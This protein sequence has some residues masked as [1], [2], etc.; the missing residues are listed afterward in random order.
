MDFYTINGVGVGLDPES[1]DRSDTYKK[2]LEKLGSSS[3][4][5][6]VIKEFISKSD[7][8]LLIKQTETAERQGDQ[9]W[10]GMLFYSEDISSTFKPYLNKIEKTLNDKFNIE[11]R[12]HTN[13][14]IVR[15]GIGH[16]LDLH[17]DE[18]S[19]VG[20]INNLSAVVYL[21]DSYEGGEICFPTYQVEIKP[22]A[23]DLVIF[24]GNLNYPHSVSTITS[25]I[26][27]S[28]PIWASY[29]D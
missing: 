17:V 28:I 1:F 16:K 4:N 9:Q 18:L 3:D 8:D 23:G 14:G 27:Y 7:T 10:D 26:R 25:G 12:V 24:P 11:C 2:N 15:W 29:L 6:M 21:N 22:S 19:V 5:I 13:P 20:Q